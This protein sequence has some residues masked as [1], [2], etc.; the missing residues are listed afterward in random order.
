M[1]SEFRSSSRPEPARYRQVS[2]GHPA[3]EVK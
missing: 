2:I 1:S 3:V